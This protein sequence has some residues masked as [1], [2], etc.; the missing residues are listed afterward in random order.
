[1]STTHTR[2]KVPKG[3]LVS[4]IYYK[5]DKV[6]DLIDSERDMYFDEESLTGAEP[7]YSYQ[8]YSYHYNSTN[9]FYNKH[10]VRSILFFKKDCITLE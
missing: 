2:I 4:I 6:P 9:L 1:M 7:D 10:V 5:K 3:T 8:Y